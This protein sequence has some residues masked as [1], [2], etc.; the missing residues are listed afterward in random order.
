MQAIEIKFSD[1]LKKN[2]MER[3][4][5]P[6]I[7]F[8]GR[9]L[10]HKEL[11]GLT[12][13]YVKHLLDMGVQQ[14]DKVGIWA[15]NSSAWVAAFFAVIKC[16]AVAVLL[17]YGL[18]K[19]DIEQLAEFTDVKLLL[20]GTTRETVANPDAWKLVAKSAGISEDKC[21]NIE[22]AT[23]TALSDEERKAVDEAES[24]RSCKDTSIFIFTTGTSAMPKAVML[25]E[26]AV[27]N[28][29]IN[30]GKN[31]LGLK[32][33]E[34]IFIALPLFH[35]FGLF[36][37]VMPLYYDGC[38]YLSG[39]LKPNA[40]VPIISEYKT[41]ILL[42]VGAVYLGL[43]NHPDFADK[44]AEVVK[45]C[46]VGGGFSTPAQMLMMETS[47]SNAKFL[48]GYGQTEC[49]P[50]ISCSI[51]S[52][53]VEKRSTTVGKPI[54]GIEVRIDSQNIDMG[55]DIPVGE[56]LVRGYNLMNG[57][58]NISAEN[59]PVDGEG[60]LHTGDIGYLDNEGFL[61]LSG[62]IKDIIIRAGE[63]IAPS[64]IEHEMM[65]L[66]E[67]AEVKVMG[68]NDHILGESVQ[69]CVVP[70]KGAN[71]DEKEVKK[72]LS[73][74]ISTIKIPENIFIYDTF[75]LNENGKL[76]QRS[77]KTSM[78]F[79]L[80]KLNIGQLLNEGIKVFGMKV[81]NTSYNITPAADAVFAIASQI[82][83]EKTKAKKIR[84]CVEEMLTE[85]IINAYEN[86]GDI[87]IGVMFM[88]NFVRILVSDNGIPMDI[89][90]NKKSSLSV[91]L[92]LEMA[93]S[94]LLM[95]DEASGKDLYC[96]DFLYESRFDIQEFL[97]KHER[98]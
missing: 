98:E 51:P 67:I 17:N 11:Y 95:S 55:N 72:A 91:K 57:Y 15:V 90:N 40:L 68:A 62:R 82:G 86:V 76:D 43:I 33:G 78:I 29:G 21:L 25:S 47:F 20:Y 69:A 79:R 23:I 80:R 1:I 87:D 46:V 60:W 39:D 35:S 44:V 36:T 65:K 56:I 85:R 38:L 14:G 83:F 92:I 2:L 45:T 32:G 27:I 88:P 61:V 4:D 7:Y 94:F 59:Q 9:F 3:S 12:E 42:S 49:A 18:K 50:L 8:A 84:L 34:Q 28:N 70:A 89:D 58:Y 75:P 97:A 77:L 6:A 31:I 30:G 64:E 24:K 22:K 74:V 63:N 5:K 96:I 13:S 19:S 81:K 37:S 48:N 71:F 26:Y 52:D 73:K 41:E 66:P 16:G 10:T 54:P 93:D 53:S